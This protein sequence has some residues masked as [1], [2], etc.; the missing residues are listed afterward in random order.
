MRATLIVFALLAPG[1]ASTYPE[2]NVTMQQSTG[3][4]VGTIWIQPLGTTVV[5]A[6]VSV[7]AEK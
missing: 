4:L 5:V 3:Q 7:A 6:D 2:P 1:L